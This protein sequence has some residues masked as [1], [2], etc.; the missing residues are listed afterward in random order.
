MLILNLSGFSFLLDCHVNV[1]IKVIIK[2]LRT[3][4]FLWNRKC[5]LGWL[6]ILKKIIGGRLLA[7]FEGIFFMSWGKIL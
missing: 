3:E 6:A 4:T 1:K 5:D 2:K 7:T